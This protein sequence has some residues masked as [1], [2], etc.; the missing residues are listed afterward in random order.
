[1]HDLPPLVSTEGTDPSGSGDIE[2]G[3][4]LPCNHV[5][6][7]RVSTC[8]LEMG[9]S[10]LAPPVKCSIAQAADLSF[11]LTVLHTPFGL[12]SGGGV[13]FFPPYLP[14]TDA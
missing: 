11:R 2:L 8:L 4:L 10:C 7:N 3:V 5:G 14:V 1:M 12:M 13:E 6:I 9:K